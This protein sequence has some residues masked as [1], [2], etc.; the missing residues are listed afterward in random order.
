MKRAVHYIQPRFQAGG[1]ERFAC[2]GRWRPAFDG[3]V[4]SPKR[5]VILYPVLKRPFVL[6]KVD[7]FMGIVKASLQPTLH[8]DFQRI[9]TKADL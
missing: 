8:A 5:R 9:L 2:H 7:C 1:Q 6:Q 3:L 4:A